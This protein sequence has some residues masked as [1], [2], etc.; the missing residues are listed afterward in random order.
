[1]PTCPSGHMS[2]AGAKF[3]ETCGAPIPAEATI[4]VTE[5]L[6]PTPPEVQAN[7]DR[8]GSVVLEVRPGRDAAPVV[9]EEAPA[10][11]MGLDE[12]AEAPREIDHLPVTAPPAIGA[13]PAPSGGPPPDHHETPVKGD[14]VGPEKESHRSK[15]KLLLVLAGVVL[16][17]LAGGAAAFAASRHSSIPSA[18]AA[19][20]T[21][22][23]STTTTSTT[24]TST[25]TTS[26]VAVPIGSG[27]WTYPSPVDQTAFQNSNALI[28]NL[29]CPQKLSCYA[30]DGAGNILFS[31]GEG[32][33]WRIVDTDPGGAAING[34]SCPTASFCVA[35]DNGGNAL[36]DSGGS[37]SDPISV[38]SNGGGFVAI[39][40]LST[41]LC[42]APDSDGNVA[43][44]T[45][46]DT[47]WA[48]ESVDPNNTP[49][50]I[51]C[52]TTSFCELTDQ[53]GNVLSWSG[54][55]WS[56]P[57]QVASTN[58]NTSELNAISCATPSF[59]VAVDGTAN[60][61]DGG[62]VY[63]FNGSNWTPE[64]VSTAAPL[65][66]IACPESGFCVA[67]TSSGG[68]RVYRGGTWSGVSQIDG[69]NSFSNIAC[70]TSSSCVAFDDKDNVLYYSSPPP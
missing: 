69:N 25:T 32:Q 52:P 22:T 56:N 12:E 58:D 28:Y 23:T 65:D 66:A 36:I 59:C 16:L 33:P 10:N 13:A 62:Y 15:L 46:V 20:T 44:F 70:S 24:T 35:V 27:N 9:E 60:S 67:T 29:S 37:W 54:R 1:M 7:S 11:Q 57:S 43:V 53:N 8:V 2:K 18:D 47:K 50:D 40:C 4:L 48:V 14:P 49:T 64:P 31:S 19:T 26:T 3:C 41:T 34:I 61:S 30:A 17:A 39:S 68:V 45:G 63:T 5:P 55:S 6:A 51:S 38:D 42:L 21:T